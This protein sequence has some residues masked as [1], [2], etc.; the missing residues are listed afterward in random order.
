MGATIKDV[1]KQAGV[2]IATVSMVVNNKAGHITEKTKQKVFDAIQD[3][4]YKPNYTARSLVSAE[5]HTMGLLVPDITNP[6]FAELAKELENSLNQ[7]GYI[8]FLC[9]SCE[10]SEREMRYVEELISRSV[11]GLIICGLTSLE[12]T[13]FDELKLRGIPFLILDNRYAL[14]DYS[15]HVDDLT[16]GKIAAE[17]LLANGH[18]K[19]AFVGSQADFAN[20]GERY[21]GYK[22][23][24][25]RASGTV[26]GFRTDLTRKGGQLIAHKVFDA[27]VTAVFC[28]NDMIAVGLYD[29]AVASGIQIPDDLSIIGYD[30]ITFADIVQP[31]L[32][33]IRQPIPQIA[34]K[35]VEH[36]R[37]M[38][39]KK[40]YSFKEEILPV[41]L[42]ERD[43]V[44][45]R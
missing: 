2:S 38:I 42:I 15:I 39:Q 41:S 19:T 20:I 35:T 6:F 31:K 28:S 9:N 12:T 8:T 14:S 27:D 36:L 21:R 3:L 24:I 30:D 5:S 22:E 26:A 44:K 29:Q 23:T 18:T 10:E 4:D 34:A 40:D 17:Y 25:E 11:D 43:S 45:K 33:T 37:K 1:A 32:T 7:A 16:G 13:I